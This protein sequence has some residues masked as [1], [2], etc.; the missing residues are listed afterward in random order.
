MTVDVLCFDWETGG[1]AQQKPAWNVPDVPCRAALL[2]AC[3]SSPGHSVQ[4]TSASGISPAFYKT[5]FVV[6]KNRKLLT[7]TYKYASVPWTACDVPK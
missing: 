1:P 3:C 2:P 7:I 5:F 4:G 6:K